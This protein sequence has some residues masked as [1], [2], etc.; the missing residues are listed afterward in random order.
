MQ[1][2]T[3]LMVNQAQVLEAACNACGGRFATGATG[4]K[5]LIIAVGEKSHLLF[6]C[7]SCGDNIMGHLKNDDAREH[8]GWDWAVPLLNGS[9]NGNGS[10]NASH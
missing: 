7:S 5:A 3:F 2:N 9:A 6:F 10:G 8:Y 1:P 4:D